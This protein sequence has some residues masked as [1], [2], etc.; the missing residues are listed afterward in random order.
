MSVKHPESEFDRFVT[1]INYGTDSE[2][3]TMLTLDKP[4]VYAVDHAN[5]DL[6]TI[7]KYLIS[8]RVHPE[9]VIHLIRTFNLPT[10]K[11]IRGMVLR[12][13]S[14]RYPILTSLSVAKEIVTSLIQTKEIPLT[15][16]SL[17]FDMASRY[18]ELWPDEELMYSS[19]GGHNLEEL[20]RWNNWIQSLNFTV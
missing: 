17:Q 5:V 4:R 2:I 13:C 12:S 19:Y 18:H 6:G 1:C 3:R 20:V 9:R 8:Q 14:K 10:E 16:E 15:P 11:L 7:Q